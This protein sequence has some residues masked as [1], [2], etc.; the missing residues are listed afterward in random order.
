MLNTTTLRLNSNNI[1]FMNRGIQKSPFECGQSFN[2]SEALKDTNITS[3]Y[4]T[5]GRGTKLGS[6]I[7]ESEQ[8]GYYSSPDQFRLA[9][10]YC[11]IR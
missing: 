10:S 8:M 7:I 9:E 2:P 1:Q 6:G 4:A 3:R 11:Y 5:V